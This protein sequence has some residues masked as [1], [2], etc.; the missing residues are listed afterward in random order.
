MAATTT[1]SNMTRLLTTRDARRAYLDSTRL[2]RI[3]KAEERRREREELERI[4]EEERQVRERA[5]ARAARER[6]RA[7]EEA[8]RAE[9]KRRG[10]P[11]VPVTASQ[12]MISV[13]FKKGEL[14]GGRGCGKE[15]G[16]GNRK[17]EGVEGKVG[18]EDQKSMNGGEKG[19]DCKDEN[20]VNSRYGE[21]QACTELDGQEL[22]DLF[23]SASQLDREV[24]GIS[25]T[26]RKGPKFGGMSQT[27]RKR[28]RDEAF[29]R[30]DPPPPKPPD[31]ASPRT[32]TILGPE[33]YDLG[34]S[35]QELL[36]IEAQGT[37]HRS[38]RDEPPSENQAPHPDSKTPA[39]PRRT[40]VKP[41]EPNTPFTE[42]FDLSSQDLRELDALAPLP[43]KHPT[44]GPSQNP[45]PDRDPETNRVESDARGQV[46]RN[47]IRDENEPSPLPTS[48]KKGDAEGPWRGT[49]I[50]SNSGRPGDTEPKDEA[51]E[52]GPR[53]AIAER[54]HDITKGGTSA[55]R[56]DSGEVVEKVRADTPRQ[57]KDNRTKVGAAKPGPPSPD[58]D[59]DEWW[60]DLDNTD[61]AT[62]LECPA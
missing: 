5:R 60:E 2:P 27:P 53:S 16:D 46:T 34:V 14:G 57:F 50:S 62:L 37:E 28:S 19:S 39:T 44:S 18:C 48:S 54:S 55:V 52:N 23:L 59:D 58:L 35:S 6:K 4:R 47:Y 33:P 21:E 25:Q 32:P 10:E 45:E 17:D 24:G 30:P 40:P 36:Q 42:S 26:P 49:G 9:K 15:A 29:R 43:T 51:S 38:V 41:V 31:R 3:S 61:L 12:G 13:F 1:L 56:N 8:E 22:D 11:V 7:R 20:Q